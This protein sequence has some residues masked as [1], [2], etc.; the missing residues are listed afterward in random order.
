M[1]SADQLATQFR[2][3]KGFMQCGKVCEGVTC[4]AIHAGETCNAS[5]LE[6]RL[7]LAE[8]GIPIVIVTLDED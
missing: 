4:M 5:D 2:E 7:E 6:E 1:R 3:A 8:V